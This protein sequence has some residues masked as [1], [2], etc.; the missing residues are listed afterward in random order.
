MA[1]VFRILYAEDEKDIRDTTIELAMRRVGGLAFDEVGSGSTYIQRA[2]EN[3]RGYGLMIVDEMMPSPNG[4]D[5]IREV[6]KFDPDTEIWMVSGSAKQEDAIAA[7]ANRW[8]QKP[9]GTNFIDDLVEF[10]E[11]KKK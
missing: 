11:S 4:L 8:Y 2:R 3:M 10:V 7:G 6:R 9:F 5:A 1:E